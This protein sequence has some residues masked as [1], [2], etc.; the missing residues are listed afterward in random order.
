MP[1]GVSPKADS[2]AAIGRKP[3]GAGGAPFWKKPTVGMLMI[4][5]CAAVCGLASTSSL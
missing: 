4:P 1:P 5:K 2:R 3:T